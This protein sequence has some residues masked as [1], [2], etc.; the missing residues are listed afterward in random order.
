MK[1][2]RDGIT[3]R[4]RPKDLKKR[5]KKKACLHL[6]TKTLFERASLNKRQG[7]KSPVSQTKFETF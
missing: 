4:Q 1:D 3:W 2:Q 5:N 7:N 6:Y